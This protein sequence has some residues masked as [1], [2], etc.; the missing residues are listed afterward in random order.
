MSNVLHSKGIPR[1]TWNFFESGHGKGITD[2]VGAGSEESS[3]QKGAGTGTLG[4][5][6]ND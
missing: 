2:G 1:A 6:E 5:D 3:R 4:P